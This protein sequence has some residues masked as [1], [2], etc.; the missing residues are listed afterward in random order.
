MEIPEKD[1]FLT[2]D[3]GLSKAVHDAVLYLHR[4]VAAPVFVSKTDEDRFQ[5]IPV[6]VVVYNEREAMVYTRPD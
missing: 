6:P 5:K 1:F 3:G 2:S 4:H